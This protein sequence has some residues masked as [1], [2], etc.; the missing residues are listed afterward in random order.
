MYA[1][2]NEVVKAINA[3]RDETMPGYELTSMHLHG[4]SITTWMVTFREGI[5]AVKVTLEIK[6]TANN[7][8]FYAS[9][10]VLWQVGS[11]GRNHDEIKGYPVEFEILRKAFPNAEIMFLDNED[12]EYPMFGYAALVNTAQGMWP[13]WRIVGWVQA[14]LND[15][16]DNAYIANKY[17]PFRELVT[18]KDILDVV[19]DNILDYALRNR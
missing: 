18:D 16:Q 3:F 7:T 6:E 1:T 2:H 10:H 11:W 19:N 12:D 15:A 8:G 14:T 5:H 4:E 9:T 17:L 13:I